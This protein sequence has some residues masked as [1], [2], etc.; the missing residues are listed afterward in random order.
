MPKC[1]KKQKPDTVRWSQKMY[2][3]EKRKKMY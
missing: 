2:A 3:G 1:E